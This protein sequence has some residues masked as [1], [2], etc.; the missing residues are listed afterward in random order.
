MTI[1]FTWTKLLTFEN[2]KDFF[3]KALEN[4]YLALSWCKK[5][6]I[7][8]LVKIFFYPNLIFALIKKLHSWE[9]SKKYVMNKFWT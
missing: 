4:M 2:G 7:L 1:I 8:S 5:K 9:T 6:K 3:L